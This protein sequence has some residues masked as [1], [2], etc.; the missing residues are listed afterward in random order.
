[1]KY[2]RAYIIGII[3][4][5]VLGLGFGTLYVVTF[6]KYHPDTTLAIEAR[7]I[8]FFEK[9]TLPIKI[10]KLATQEP[11]AHVLMPVHGVHVRQISNTWQAPR[12]GA[13]VHEGQDIFAAKS[14]PVFSGTAGYVVLARTVELGGNAIYVVGAGGRRY[15]YAHL[16][17]FA[18]GI[19]VGQKVTTDTVI[20]F[21]GNTGNA[22]TTPPHLHFG[23]YELRQA[24]NPLPLL[25]DR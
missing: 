5:C 7:V 25:R 19:H 13:R 2:R 17:R 23:A 9:L 4:S 11:D 8:H 12:D 18:D 10:A 20:G 21:V 16:D 14:T 6:S 15:Y 1:M 3:F 24:I 22:T